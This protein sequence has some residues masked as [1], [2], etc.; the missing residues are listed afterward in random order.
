MKKKNQASTSLYPIFWREINKS[1]LSHNTEFYSTDHFSPITKS[2]YHLFKATFYF[3]S[4]QQNEVIHNFDLAYDIHPENHNLE[5]VKEFYTYLQMSKFS[6]NSIFPNNKFG[7]D[8]WSPRMQKLRELYLNESHQLAINYSRAICTE[9][10]SLQEITEFH[11]M[12]FVA[13]YMLNNLSDSALSLRLAFLFA[14]TY[15]RV[16]NYINHTLDY[17]KYKYEE[18]VIEKKVS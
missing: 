17:E 14:P 3:K 13:F 16:L 6:D 7:V 11:L 12:R 18:N 8:E 4:F 5:Y 1:A 10:L 9:K 15:E 2:N